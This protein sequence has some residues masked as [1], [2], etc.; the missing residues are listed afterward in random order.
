MGNGTSAVKSV[1]DWV[2]PALDEDGAAVALEKF[3]FADA[4]G[5]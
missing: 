2:A 1:A 3:V 5:S 4:P